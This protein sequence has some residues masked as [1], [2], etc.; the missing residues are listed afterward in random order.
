MTT[1]FIAGSITIK[2]LDPLVQVRLMNIIEMKHEIIVG[3][4]DGADSS[5]QR[6]LLEGGAKNVTVYCSGDKPRNNLG[7]WPVNSVTT[8][9]TQGSRAYFTAKDIAMAEAAK[10][11]LMIWD[12]KSTGTLSNVTELLTRKKNALVF[13]NKDKVFHKVVSVIDLEALVARMAAASRL[14]ADTKIGLFERIKNLRSREQVAEI[15]ATR[16]V[17]NIASIAL[18]DIER[19]NVNAI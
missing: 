9:H 18:S 5:I 2:H 4:A 13:I 1:V 12:A 14:K 7:N 17:A 3:D 11:G 10:V 16:S 15:L 6:F 8:Y 19:A